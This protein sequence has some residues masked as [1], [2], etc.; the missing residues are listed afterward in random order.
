MRLTSV[1]SNRGTIVDVQGRGLPVKANPRSCAH[2]FIWLG[3]ARKVSRGSL[4]S[5]SWVV[6]T[7]AENLSKALDLGS[8]MSPCPHAFT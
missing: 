8:V 7:C 3:H 6:L 2:I 5:R 4:A 1:T